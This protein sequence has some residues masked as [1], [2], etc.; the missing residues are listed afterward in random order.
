MQGNVFMNFSK[1]GCVCNC[2]TVSIVSIWIMSVFRKLVLNEFQKFVTGNLT[3]TSLRHDLNQWS[4]YSP[5]D[6]LVSF[7]PVISQFTLTF[8]AFL[9]PRQRSNV[10]ILWHAIPSTFSPELKTIRNFMI[11]FEILNVKYS[12]VSITRPGHSR[13]LNGCLI[14]TFSKYPYQAV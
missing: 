12:K 13:L 4:E 11:S 10:Y 5:L 2:T 14:E 9:T 7:F 6:L 1:F 3:D 8:S